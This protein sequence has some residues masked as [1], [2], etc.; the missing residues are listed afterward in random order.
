MKR[1]KLEMYMTLLSSLSG[2]AES[3]GNVGKGI[4]KIMYA[5]NINCTIA[6]EMLAIAEG[7][8]D[9]K[10]T[11]QKNRQNYVLTDRGLSFVD[12]WRQY[13]EFS[14]KLESSL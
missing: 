10:K 13:K 2:N 1:S 7:R 3:S 14:E 6:K 4:T 11:K 12:G 5:T 8:G 9:V